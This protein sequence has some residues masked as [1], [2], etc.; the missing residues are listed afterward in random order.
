MEGGAWHELARFSCPYAG[1]GHWHSQSS[2]AES[3]LGHC[4]PLCTGTVHRSTGDGGSYPRPPSCRCGQ[5]LSRAPRALPRALRV[6]KG[7]NRTPRPASLPV[8]RGYHLTR[9]PP[10]HPGRQSCPLV[11]QLLGEGGTLWASLTWVPPLA[12]GQSQC[13]PEASRSPAEELPSGSSGCRP[14]EQRL[15]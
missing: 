11:V 15:P 12:G 1:T 13:F 5:R 9:V 10:P 14:Q 3:S 7:L 2:G 4:D 8:P 6:K